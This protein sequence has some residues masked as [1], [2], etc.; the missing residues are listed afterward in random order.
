MCEGWS[1]TGWTDAKGERRE[2]L[3]HVPCQPP[4][5]VRRLSNDGGISNSQS[6]LPSLQYANTFL[7]GWMDVMR[8]GGP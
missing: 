2:I 1:K 8:S 5:T 7:A 3:T 4:Q 6:L